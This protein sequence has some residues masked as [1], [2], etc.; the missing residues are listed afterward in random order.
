MARNPIKDQIAIVGVGSTGFTRESGSRSRDALVAQACIAAV[1][2]AGVTKQDVDGVCGTLPTAARVVSM[3]GLPEVT[4]YVNQP[5][6]MVFTI[7]D[8]MNAIFSGSAD[9]VLA[10]HAMYR[11]PAVSRAAAADPLRR[12]LGWAGTPAGRTWRSDPESV[13]GS[14]G[15]TAWASRYLHEYGARREHL[16][17][18]AVNDRTNAAQNPLAAMR[19]PLS[20]DDYLAARMVRDPLCILDMDVPVDGADAFVLTSA[21]RARDLTDTPVLIHAATT[22]TT[23]KNDEDQIPDLGH[24]GQQ[25]V[26]RELRAKSD[27]WIPDVD[28]YFPY[29][30]FSFITLSWMENVGWCGPGE[31][32]EFVE[33]H[34][35]KDANKIMINGRVPV[36]PH[37][38]ALSE[39]ATQGSGHVRE[40]VLQLR[41]QAGERQVPDARTAFLTPGGFFFNAQG[42]VLRRD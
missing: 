37:G 31:G 21:E 29:D 8:A 20:L 5:P 9:V 15:Y 14:V 22:G 17:Y 32:G 4:H 12:N 2:D 11:S 30:G 7:V 18:V 39:G 35:D 36:N 23:A 1:L 26:A 41:G 25:V 42:L 38:G 3:L 6:P 19:E 16:G 28:V 34:W 27:I 24:H 33:N 40:A 10:Y 13:A